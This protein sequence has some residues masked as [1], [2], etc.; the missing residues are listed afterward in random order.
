MKR[1]RS[2]TLLGVLVGDARKTQAAAQPLLPARLLDAGNYFRRSFTKLHGDGE[3]RGQ[4][5]LAEPAL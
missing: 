4:R 2:L 1:I 5:R 3:N